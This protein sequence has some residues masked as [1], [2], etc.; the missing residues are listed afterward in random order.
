MTYW[1][2][3]ILLVTIFFVSFMAGRELSNPTT[4]PGQE[5]GVELVTFQGEDQHGNTYQCV[6]LTRGNDF[7]I[8]CD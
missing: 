8:D 2:T 1:Y 5:V 3:G 6:V 7:G 4:Y